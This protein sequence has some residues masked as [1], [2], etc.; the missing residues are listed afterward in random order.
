[1]VMLM[2]MGAR[3]LEGRLSPYSLAFAGAALAI[4]LP[5][6]RKGL[7]MAAVLATRSILT[8]TDTIRHTGAIIREEMENIVAEARE[9]DHPVC[10]SLEMRQ[11]KLASATSQG[12]MSVSRKAHSLSEKISRFAND[13]DHR[14]VPHEYDGLEGEN[15]D[16]KL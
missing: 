6:V 1:M 9:T 14:N 7:R 2:R 15:L 4:S 13:Q 10:T 16:P 5:P 3:L 8:M 11:R 12:L